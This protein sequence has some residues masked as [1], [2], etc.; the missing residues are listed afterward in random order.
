MT[1]FKSHLSAS[2]HHKRMDDAT[3]DVTCNGTTLYLKIDSKDRIVS[4]SYEGDSDVWMSSLCE[5][6][7]DMT[8][9]EARLVDLRHWELIWKDDQFF[10]DMKLEA[11]DKIFSVPLELL[12]AA[13]DLYRGREDLYHEESALICRCFGVREKDVLDFLRT[14]E[15]T[16]LEALSKATRAGMGCRSC[17]PQ[18]RQWLMIPKEERNR[19]YK[20][21]PVADWIEMIDNALSRFP[22]AAAWKMNVESMK[23][24]VVILS[25]DREC[26]QKEEEEM[27]RKV[28]GFFSSAVDGDLGFFLR[29]S[30]QR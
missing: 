22:E 14:S 21:K 26:T 9:T 10:W 3:V 1:G 6:L 20:S 27:G 2:R 12:H 19:F 5:L 24:D 11:E 13:I 4:A 18:L 15:D 16:S 17:V 7:Q 28:Q 29:R 25:Y 30:R 23:G 8:L